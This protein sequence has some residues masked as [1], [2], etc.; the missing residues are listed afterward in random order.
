M[1]K[2]ALVLVLLPALAGCKSFTWGSQ[3][4]LT[5]EQKALG[6]QDVDTLS[7]SYDTENFFRG[8]RRRSDGRSNAFARDL[9]KIT[10]F[11]DRHFWNYDVNDPAVNYPTNTTKLEHLGRFGLSTLTSFPVVDEFT[12]R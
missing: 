2:L 12:T 5:P 3:T 11:V 7:D 1:R 6:I 4:T 9:A 8:V 10:D